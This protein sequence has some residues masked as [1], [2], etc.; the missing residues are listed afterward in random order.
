MSRCSS[1]ATKVLVQCSRRPRRCSRRGYRRPLLNGFRWR[2]GVGQLDLAG[3]K[4][5]TKAAVVQE[6]A[7]VVETLEEGDTDLSPSMTGC[8][9]GSAEQPFE[10][11]L[12]KVRRKV[13]YVRALLYG[14]QLDGDVVA[15]ARAVVGA[16]VSGRRGLGRGRAVEGFWIGEVAAGECGPAQRDFFCAAYSCLPALPS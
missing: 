8:R 5:G 7:W 14:P 9:R 3:E 16:D 12:A 2:G 15:A 10:Q 11:A 13:R 1:E 4:L 6:G